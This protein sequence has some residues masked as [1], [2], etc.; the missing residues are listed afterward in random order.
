MTRL[1]RRE[2][3]VTSSIR[4]GHVTISGCCIVDDY[5]GVRNLN[6]VRVINRPENLA[7]H[8]RNLSGK[9]QCGDR[10]KDGNSGERRKEELSGCKPASIL[11]WIQHGYESPFKVGMAGHG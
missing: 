10:Q 8:Q 7:G 9:R 11:N 2:Q 3:K 1:D 5:S 4:D 6:P